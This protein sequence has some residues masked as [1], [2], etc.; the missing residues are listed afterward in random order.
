M[1]VRLFLIK[2]HYRS[3]LN[4]TYDSLDATK[5]DMKKIIKFL[6]I[7]DSV[8]KT[9]SADNDIEVSMKNCESEILQN[10][11]DDMNVSNA[12]VALL[13]FTNKITAIIINI[14][15]SEAQTIKNFVF[16]LDDI[17]GF[18]KIIYQQ[19]SDDLKNRMKKNSLDNEIEKRSMLKEN[20]DF[21]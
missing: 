3:K 19:H 18:M 16:K 13:E 15:I 4:F 12:I 8:E 20:G 7:L 17:F 2:K 5:Q 9:E 1:I 10:L 21:E 11:S 14:S 6:L